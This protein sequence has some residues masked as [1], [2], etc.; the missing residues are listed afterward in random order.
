MIAITGW[1]TS[2]AVELRKLLP[3][4]ETAVRAVAADPDFPLDAD[5]YLFAAGL[6][7]PKQ[8]RDQTAE[9]IREGLLVNHGSVVRACDVLFDVNPTARVVVIGSESAYTGS[10]DDVYASA[11]ANLHR[12]VETKKLKHPGQQLVC[13]APTII[14]DS[15]MT[16]RRKDL[17]SV[18]KRAL[19]NPKRRWL[20][21]IEVARLVHFCLFQDEGYLS[22]VVLRLHGGPA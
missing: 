6:L 17:V 12:Y 9:E 19:K 11:K 1:N 5:R 10:Y 15:G 2:I 14:M 16:Q 20:K 13:V 3:D 21:A 18:E 22:G 4:G 7:R 8:H